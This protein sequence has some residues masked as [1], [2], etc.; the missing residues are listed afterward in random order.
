M[1]AL[2]IDLDARFN[3]LTTPF[4]RW[5]WWSE[6]SISEK[7]SDFNVNFQIQKNLQHPLSINFIIFLSKNIY[8]PIS[9]HRIMYLPDESRLLSG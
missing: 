9:V 1:F 4:A 2:R 8:K 5:K 7:C 3:F 6:N